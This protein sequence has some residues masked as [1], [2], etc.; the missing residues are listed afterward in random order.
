VNSREKKIADI[1][2]HG[3]AAVGRA[4]LLAHLDGKRLCASK[5]IIAFCFDCMGYFEDGKTGCDNPLCPLHPWSPYQ[6]KDLPAAQHR[7]LPEKNGEGLGCLD[8]PKSG[9]VPE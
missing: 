3:I 2:E 7:A 4:E 5:A 9:E 1:R 8:V 6:A